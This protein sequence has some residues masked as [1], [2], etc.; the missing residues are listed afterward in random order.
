MYARYRRELFDGF[1]FNDSFLVDNY[2]ELYQRRPWIESLI[3][4]GCKKL[5]NS[6]EGISADCSKKNLPE[7]LELNKQHFQILMDLTGSDPD[8]Y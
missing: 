8:W 1:E 2:L 3:K 5:V 7:I 6:I 4:L